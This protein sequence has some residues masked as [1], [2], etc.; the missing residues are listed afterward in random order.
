MIAKPI[1]PESHNYQQCLIRE[2]P[3]EKKRR[4]SQ[5]LD[6]SAIHSRTKIMY[7]AGGGYV[8]DN[9]SPSKKGA[10]GSVNVANNLESNAKRSK[11]K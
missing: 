4:G 6:L 8:S 1:I 2:D 7:S 11:A 5:D 3:K 9:M 10:K